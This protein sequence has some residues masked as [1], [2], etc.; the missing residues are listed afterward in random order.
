MFKRVLIANRGEVAVRVIRACQ[1]LDIETVAVFSEGDR[2]ALHSRLADQAVCIG[3]AP[4]RDSYLNVA[5]IISAA[6][7]TGAQ[8]IHPGYGFLA[9]NPNFAEI[10]ERVNI[11]FIGP[12]S[13]VIEKM[14]N[15]AEARKLMLESEVPVVPGT[16]GI[17]STEKDA[18]NFAHNIGYPVI[19]KAAAGGGG[20]GMRIVQNDTE[21]SQGLNTARSESEAA[22]G[23]GDVYVEKYIEEPRHVEVQ[24]LADEHGHVVHLGERDC[25][26]QT[27]R[28][29]KMLEESPCAALNPSLRN[30]V[31][32]AAIR[33]AKAVG[34][35]NAGTVEF[36]LGSR[37]EFFFMEM[38]TRIQVEHPVSEM[39]SGIDL[40]KEQIR[41]AA[42]ERLG[43]RQRDVRLSGHAIECRIT[44]E[45]PKKRFAPSVGKI[46]KY[47][48]PGGIG[49]RVDSHIF[50]GYVMPPYYDS[51]LAKVI[52]HGHNRAEAIQRMQR[53]LHE[54][55]IEGVKTTLSFHRSILSNAF[56]KKGEVYTNFIKRRMGEG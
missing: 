53:S 49:V 7:I 39:V 41:V 40:V 6:F 50:S 20:R 19:I 12:T 18:I 26:L 27:S 33:A 52:C 3:P 8:A 55:V 11:K 14:G 2:D 42:G 16:E 30:R 22:F 51:L 35:T 15:K 44:A 24:I 21:L 1:E 17:I 4:A 45:D 28:H 36:L 25:S 46:T 31:G 43:Y 10:C 56:F 9:E 47:H 34:Y 54:M 29:Q 32:E 5:N 38:N 23:N 37:N 13:Q 48:A